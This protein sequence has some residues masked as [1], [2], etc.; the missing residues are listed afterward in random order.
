MTTLQGGPSARGGPPAPAHPGTLPPPALADGI[1]LL[2]ETKGSGY[3]EAPSL[4]RRAD[5]QTI[6]LT[7]LLYVVLEAID[8]RRD[9]AAIAEQASD[10]YGKV[11]SAGNVQTLITSQLLP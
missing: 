6:Q 3:K 4:V 5:G 11:V 7:R 1:Q 2:G 9:L 10:S 8:G